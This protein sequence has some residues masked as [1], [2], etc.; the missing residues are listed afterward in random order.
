M[1]ARA[2]ENKESSPEPSEEAFFT[3]S[4]SLT[5]HAAKFREMPSA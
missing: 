5:S 3:T 4:S 1:Y 2:E